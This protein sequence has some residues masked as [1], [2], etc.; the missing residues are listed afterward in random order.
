[1]FFNDEQFVTHGDGH[2]SDEPP[3]PHRRVV[4]LFL[5][6]IT[7]DEG[8]PLEYLHVHHGRTTFLATQRF[9]RGI[10]SRGFLLIR[11]LLQHGDKQSYTS[12]NRTTLK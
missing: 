2:P 3:C 11:V 5:F 1:M 12:R 6:W 10:R 7:D 8:I 4:Q 9:Q